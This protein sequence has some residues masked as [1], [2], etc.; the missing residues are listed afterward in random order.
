MSC[1]PLPNKRL[2]LTG[3]ERLK[4]SRVLCAGVLSRCSRPACNEVRW[5]SRRLTRAHDTTSHPIRQDPH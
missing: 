4:G 3:G 2:K 1:V 5:G